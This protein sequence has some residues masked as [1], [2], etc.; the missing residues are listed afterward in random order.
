MKQLVFDALKTSVIS[1]PILVFPNTTTLF[2]IEADNS[3][4]ITEVSRSLT[5]DFIFI[6]LLAF[7]FIL[8]FIFILFSIFRTTW[9]RVDRSC[10]H[11][12]HN[13]MAKSQD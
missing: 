11:I 8:F 9:V 6:V 7:Y 5:V 13:L 1:T 4:Y 3:N 2:Y 10:C 12:S